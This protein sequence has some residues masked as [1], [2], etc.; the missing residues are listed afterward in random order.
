MKIAKD[1]IAAIKNS[2]AEGESV[3]T[4]LDGGRRSFL[5]AQIMQIA[6]PQSPVLTFGAFQTNARKA[7]VNKFVDKLGIQAYS[8]APINASSD[9]RAIFAE[10]KTNAFSIIDRQPYHEELF[11]KLIA[12]E[13]GNLV[14]AYLWN[15]TFSAWPIS[16]CFTEGKAFSPFDSWKR[17]DFKE[18]YSFFNTPEIP[19]CQIR[20][21]DN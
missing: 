10:Y 5:L 12:F 19:R 7:V 13:N 1:T 16:E 21:L 3:I 8:F 11:D 4:W 14:P 20:H 15:T 17:E 18:A 6:L 9:G 2:V